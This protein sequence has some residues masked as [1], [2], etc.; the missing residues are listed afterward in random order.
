MKKLFVLLTTILG[1]LSCNNDEILQQEIQ[2]INTK[3]IYIAGYEKNPISDDLDRAKFWVNGVE[4]LLTNGEKASKAYGITTISSTTGTQVLVAGFEY[5]NNV[6][7]ARIWRDKIALTI[8]TSGGESS[9]T[10][11]CTIGDDYYACGTQQN[12]SG[13]QAVFWKNGIRTFLTTQNG[14]AA[15]SAITVINNDV[16]VCGYLIENNYKRAVYWKNNGNEEVSL[17]TSPLSPANVTA[18]AI[19]VKNNKVYVGGNFKSIY[20]FTLPTGVIW[21]DGVL[22]DLYIQDTVLTSIA[23]D[24]TGSIYHAGSKIRN[25][26]PVA[27]IWKDKIE[28]PF[29]TTSVNSRID[30]LFLTDSNFYKAGFSDGVKASYW[31]ATNVRRVLDSKVSYATAIWTNE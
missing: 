15:A 19:V 11:I 27:A 9:A 20:D 4:N 21:V 8:D 24:N 12:A 13:T 7:R 2:Q 25:G 5:E 1:I 29:E 17:S 22:T 14:Y 3:K 28:Q 6:M 26:N 30:A 18:V 10:G 23:V 16:Y 31:Q